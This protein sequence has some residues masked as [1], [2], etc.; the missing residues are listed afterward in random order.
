MEDE[1]GHGGSTS[2]YMLH[3]VER[4]RIGYTCGK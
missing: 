4:P 1:I 2:I 3:L